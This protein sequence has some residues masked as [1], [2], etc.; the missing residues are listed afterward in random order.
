MK[1]WVSIVALATLLMTNV[2]SAEVAMEEGAL[3]KP[4]TAEI[5]ELELNR[6]GIYN[7]STHPLETTQG[8]NNALKWASQ[9][10]VKVFKVPAGTYLIAKGSNAEDSSTNAT[11]QM[12]SNMT[13]EL[14]PDTVL[15]KETNGY[16]GYSVIYVGNDVVNA[17]I[18]G[19]TLRGD[20][21]T[22]DYSQKMET[23]SAGTHEWGYGISIV[24]GEKVVVDG[25]KIEKMTG[26]GVMIGGSTIFG[27]Y[28][29][30]AQ[31]ELGGLDAMGQPTSEAGKVRS[32]D[33]NV[34]NFDS[35]I[36]KKYN[37]IFMWLPEGVTPGSTFDVYYY[38]TDG[39]FIQADKGL[40]YYSGESIIPQGAD[41]FRTVFDAPS[42]KGVSVN[43]MTIA[44][45]KNIVIKN[46]N[47]GY[48]RR[49][50][51]T[52]GGENVQ[53]INNEIHHTNGTAPQAGID[54]EPGFFPAKNHLIKGNSFIDNQIQIVLAYGETVNIDGNYF[55]QTSN[56]EGGVGLH[57]HKN[58][59]GDIN[60]NNN[61][62]N[63]SSMTILPDNVQMNNNEYVNAQVGLDGD[64][65]VFKNGI[66]TG[67]SLSVGGGSGQE[68]SSVTINQNGIMPAALYIWDKLVH[69]KDVSI[70][71]SSNR[72]N[73]KGLIIGYGSNNNVYDNLTVIDESRV[74]TV[75]P[76]GTYNNAKLEA[77]GLGINREGKYV[78]NNSVIK[79]KNSLLS[80]DKLYGE[81]P[82]VS[83]KDTTF[84]L[85]ENVGYGAA[86]YV[87]GA[88]NFNLI[89]ST[90]LAKNNTNNAP[91]VK[92]GPYG[93]PKA[94]NIFGIT[95]KGNT[96][97]TKTGVEVIGIDTSNAGTDAPKYF[98]ENNTLNNAKLNL[99]PKD[100]NLNNEEVMMTVSRVAG[101]IR[102][103]L[104]AGI[105]G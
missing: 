81:A 89:N 95:M 87:Q 80:V 92:F 40:R 37:N 68:I 104:V 88:K 36:Y 101:F 34:T 57:I 1:K 31:L 58:Y 66:F 50:G 27:S 62:F 15:V 93:Y 44:N 20:R 24:G 86:I 17:T 94:T 11:I 63:G 21:D 60:V 65:Q 71:G 16:E 91:I 25:V 54:I 47:I 79:D 3:V 13:L 103:W 72:D 23:G 2:A 19:G 8:I 43:R 61:K 18:N 42:T 77:G 84:E 45:A 22:H 76:A 98:F 97:T 9:N 38:K 102:P 53:I 67:S 99:T 4:A 59:R 35:P 10:G 90:I 83:I 78:I 82:D 26:D 39:S 55:E 28:I 46:N 74:G 96:M 73:T 12:V 29:E 69:L 30:E 41:Y 6:W 5:Y 85:T 64:N 49:Q 100:V 51:I 105:I 52:A 70:K 14:S 32:N 56:V 7:D 48:N 75:L 33:R